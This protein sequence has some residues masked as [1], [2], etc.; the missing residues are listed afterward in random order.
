[1]SQEWIDGWFVVVLTGYFTLCLAKRVQF[2]GTYDA[3]V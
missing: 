2:K 1:M 3:S